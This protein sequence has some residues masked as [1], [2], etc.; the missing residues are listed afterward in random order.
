M[1]IAPVPYEVAAE[2]ARLLRLVADKWEQDAAML[3]DH[4]PAWSACRKMARQYRAAADAL[5]PAGTGEA[6]AGERGG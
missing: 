5:L 6:E 2:A 3:F 1:R 4:P